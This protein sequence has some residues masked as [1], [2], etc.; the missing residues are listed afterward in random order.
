MKKERIDGAGR[1]RTRQEEER[2]SQGERGGRGGGG[3]GQGID[4]RGKRMIAR[5]RTEGE[6]R[7]F[8]LEREGSEG[9]GEA[10]GRYISK[11]EMNQK[12]RDTWR[13]RAG[14]KG[15]TPEITVQERRGTKEEGHGDDRRDGGEI[16]VGSRRQERRGHHANNCHSH[17]L[18]LPEKS[19]SVI[20]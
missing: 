11:R 17:V 8:E 14:A 19:P 12:R 10:D 2:W 7:R 4:R 20:Q 16:E 6:G 9:E 18:T 3:G 5:Y 13:D 1:E 15:G